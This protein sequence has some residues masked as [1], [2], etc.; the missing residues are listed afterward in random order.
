MGF[1]LLVA[2]LASDDVCTRHLDQHLAWYR[3]Y[4]LP[5]PP[6]QASL[7]WYTPEPIVYRL[8]GVKVVEPG[9][10]GL[11]FSLDGRTVLGA[12][13][14]PIAVASVTCIKPDL[15][16]LR[17][18]G[19]ID[20]PIGWHVFAVACYERGWKSMAITAIRMWVLAG[21]S[22]DTEA[23]VAAAAWHQWKYR[24]RHD[25]GTP[26][27]VIAKYL[28][29]AAR[30]HGDEEFARAVEDAATPRN[31]PPGS[32]DALI[33]ACINLTGPQPHG[34]NWLTDFRTDPRYL[35]V[36]RRGLAVVPALIAHLDDARITRAS[37]PEHR[38]SRNAS[39]R[40]KDIALDLLVQLHG[41]EF[42]T[43]DRNEL[44]KEIALW[45][46]DAL[47][48]GEAKYLTTR[49]VG[50]DDEQEFPRE[51]LLRLIA[52][53]YPE[54]LPD[55]FRKIIDERALLRNHSWLFARAI[56][57]GP[58]PPPDKQKIF[59][60]AACCEYPAVRSAGIHFLRPYDPVRA[61]KLLL[62]ALSKLSTRP[63]NR[64]AL[65]ARTVA[66]GTDR[67]EWRAFGLALRQAEPA[68][69]RRLLNRMLDAEAPAA[70]KLRL[71]LA[72]EYLTDDD[73]EPPFENELTLQFE[74]R[75]TVA[76]RL[77]EQLGLEADVYQTEEEWAA[78]RATLRT[79]VN[80]ELRR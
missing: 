1:A 40:V 65:Y 23:E 14:P 79:R 3:H 62:L 32:D 64:A 58:I 26:L 59:D 46:A 5:L 56:E 55:V 51:M 52:E 20:V 69:R 80:E 78:F 34:E 70:R 60:Y 15:S 54:R 12:Y 76:L 67:D 33:D 72:A 8:R 37:G 41:G 24:I 50:E 36:A 47:K 11:G 30:F 61:K 10:P 39:L 2:T 31:S 4:G 71:A 21:V 7:V 74:V 13:G 44:L 16:L 35:A 27:P 25:P 22:A 45:Y 49:L 9:R 38:A 48:L 17:D 63:S 6:P 66:E 19:P 18:E 77:A 68:G 42:K 75:N 43:D 73:T 57:D 53:K 29:R 28:K